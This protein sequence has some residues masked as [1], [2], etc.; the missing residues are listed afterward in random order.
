MDNFFLDIAW[1]MIDDPIPNGIN[2]IT[3]EKCIYSSS[4]DPVS[5]NSNHLKPKLPLLLTKINQ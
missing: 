5:S 3:N 2:L 4:M 1:V